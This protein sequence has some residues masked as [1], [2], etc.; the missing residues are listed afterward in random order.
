MKYSF[1]KNFKSNL[2]YN[3]NMSKS[4]WFQTGGKSFAYC[5]V[6]SYDDLR[7][8]LIQTPNE[9]PIF[10]LGAGSNVLI[11]DGGFKGII[12]KLG[13]E[14]NKIKLENDKIVAGA[15]ALDIMLSQFAA[16]NSIKGFEFLSGIPGTVG[17][18]IKMN[19]GCYGSETKEIIDRVQI[20]DRFGEESF[21]TNKNLDFKYRRSAI[22][23]NIFVKKA[24]FKAEIGDTEEILSNRNEIL[25]KRKESQPLQVKTG[26]ST[27]K[28][29]NNQFAAKLI[30]KAGCKGMEVGDAIVSTKHANFLINQ[31]NA[32]AGD[33]ENLGEKI[34][35][36]VFN[37][38]H[39]MLEWEIKIIG[40]KL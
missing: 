14:F 3:F 20:I 4:T 23:N 19:A 2:K 25:K 5:L 28:N 31:N 13:K 33:I 11:R 32:S 12:I 27:F 10:L 35:E 15:S 40:D 22:H 34:K 16:K 36:K 26:G 29:P 21:L 39:I 30:E 6:N 18:A 24:F 1:K 38:F 8:I 37:K 17:G 9:M 7:L